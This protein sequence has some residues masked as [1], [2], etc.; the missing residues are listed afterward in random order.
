MKKSKIVV[1]VVIAIVVLAIVGIVLLTGNDK[2]SNNLEQQ[3]PPKMTEQEKNN[4]KNEI[5]YRLNNEGGMGY[6]ENIIHNSTFYIK[7]IDIIWE[8]T[9]GGKNI[10]NISNMEIFTITQD[11]NIKNI[12]NYIKDTEGNILSFNEA[13]QNYMKS[14]NFRNT[15][16]G[17]DKIYKEYSKDIEEL[18]NNQDL[19]TEEYKSKYNDVIQIWDIYSK[20]YELYKSYVENPTEYDYQVFKNNM[21][22]IENE[23]K[24]CEVYKNYELHLKYPN[25]Y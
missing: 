9:D 2:S 6:V 11:N 10:N 3:E 19:I 1:P 8:Y 21:E 5:E 24:T 25:L 12:D 23:M 7:N 22:Q 18:K 13:I 20:E 17:Y 16:I 15:K 4:L 14:D